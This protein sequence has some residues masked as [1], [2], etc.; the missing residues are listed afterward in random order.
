MSDFKDAAIEENQPE[1]V[2]NFVVIPKQSM[3]KEKGRITCLRKIASSVLCK[4]TFDINS[5]QQTGSN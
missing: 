4:E 1:T 2:G 5:V 3:F